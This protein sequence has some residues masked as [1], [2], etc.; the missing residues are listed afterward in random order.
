MKPANLDTEELQLVR[1]AVELEMADIKGGK[2]K[3][4]SF[5]EI[6]KILKT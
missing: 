6:R 3:T 2:A 4:H 5:D 1:K